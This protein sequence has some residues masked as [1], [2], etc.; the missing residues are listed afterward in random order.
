MCACEHRGIIPSVTLNFPL[1]IQKAS[2]GP[3]LGWESQW[4]SVSPWEEKKEMPSKMVK[5]QQHPQRQSP[6]VIA[7]VYGMKLMMIMM[8]ANIYKLSSIEILYLCY[9]IEH[10]Y[11]SL[12]N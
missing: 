3:N 12:K 4:E 5:Y 6:Q 2:L 8:I 1:L 10:S 11:S 9:P 7:G